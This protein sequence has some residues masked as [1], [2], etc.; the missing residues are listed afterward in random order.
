MQHGE[1][2]EEVKRRQSKAQLIAPASPTQGSRHVSSARS[3]RL[4]NNG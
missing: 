1:S 2:Q 3:I 4:I